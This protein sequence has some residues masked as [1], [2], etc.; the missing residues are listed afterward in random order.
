MVTVKEDVAKRFNRNT[1]GMYGMPKAAA[2]FPQMK[3]AAAAPAAVV[4]IIRSRR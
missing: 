1:R 2:V 3:D 4:A